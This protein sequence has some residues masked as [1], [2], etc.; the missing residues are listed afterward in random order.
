MAGAGYL[1]RLSLQLVAPVSNGV[2]LSQ[3]R[4]SAGNLT[5]NG[6]L[7]TAG[8]ATFDVARRVGIISSGNDSALSFTITGTD[9]NGRAQTEI[10][11]GANVGTV[12]T[13]RDFLTVSNVAT[14]GATAANVTVGTTGTASTAPYIVDYFATTANY[15]A[16]VENAGGSTYSIEAANDDVSP[17][18]DLTL[19]N[20]AWA[21]VPNFSGISTTG[22]TLGTIQ[23]PFVML[24]LTVTAGTTPVNARF[25]FPLVGGGA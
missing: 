8:V 20:P 16:I 3:S 1:K 11:L 19:A 23:G 4:G 6:S 10:L 13:K 15:T 5:I 24:R 17:D 21:T 22:N 12:Q 9:R 2:A 25:A 14:S 7:A 18:Y